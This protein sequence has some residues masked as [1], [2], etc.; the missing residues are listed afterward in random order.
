MV[1]PNFFSPHA[2]G[3]EDRQRQEPLEHRA[4]H[5]SD[6]MTLRVQPFGM[7]R[8]AVRRRRC[9]ILPLFYRS[10]ILSKR[11]VAAFGPRAPL[12]RA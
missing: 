9:G 2:P 1:R 7:A 11:F 10:E 8:A 4:E 5:A 6:Q 3:S 12:H